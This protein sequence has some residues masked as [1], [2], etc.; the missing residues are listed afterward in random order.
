MLG[1]ILLC[2]DH[3]LP[4]AARGE[5]DALRPRRPGKAASS[6]TPGPAGQQLRG[7]ARFHGK[8]TDGPARA[9]GAHP[10]RLPTRNRRVSRCATA[11]LPAHKQRVLRRAT[12]AS[13]DAQ[14]ARL[15]ARKP[16]R[17]PARRPARFPA[18]NWCVLRRAP[19]AS[20]DAYPARLEARSRHASAAC[21]VFAF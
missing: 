13:C 8:R 20:T 3:P 21:D 4:V 10:A 6:A 5:R 15:P 14:P 7:S 18:R 12:G 16:A 17:L 11:H 19:D 2:S 1:R 9:R